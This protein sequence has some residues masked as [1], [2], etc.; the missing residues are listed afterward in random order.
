MKD[1]VTLIDQLGSERVVVDGVD[2]V[3]KT[4]VLLEVLNI[5]DRASGKI[6]DHVD[7]IATLDV[8]VAEMRSDKTRAT[9]DKYSQT[10]LLKLATKGTK[11]T[12]KSF[13]LFVLLC[14]PIRFVLFCGP[15]RRTNV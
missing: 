14:G 9:C 10:L 5:F 15:T 6:V 2:R 13:V 1:H 3:M 11:V 7:F 4:R 8:S 12:K